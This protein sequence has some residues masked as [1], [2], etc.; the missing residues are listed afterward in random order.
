M[1]LIQCCCLGAHRSTSNIDEASYFV[2]PPAAPPGKRGTLEVPGKHQYAQ[3]KHEQQS[4]YDDKDLP[5]SSESEEEEEEDQDT[6][7]VEAEETNAKDHKGKQQLNAEEYVGSAHI[8]SE[9]A[10]LKQLRLPSCSD[11]SCGS[12]SNNHQYVEDAE[13]LTAAS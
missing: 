5:S 4:Y 2:V 12:S 11:A 8:D 13:Y 1:G 7:G 6:E 10:R 3:Q 9:I